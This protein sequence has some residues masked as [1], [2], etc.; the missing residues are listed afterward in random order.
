MLGR[1][2]AVSAQEALNLLLSAFPKKPLPEEVVILSECLGR[3]INRDVLAPEDLPGF[4]R[5]TVD[6]FA[7][8]SADTF[9]S[10]SYLSVIGEVRMGSAP[11]F[12]IKRGQTVRIPTGGMLP[13]GADSVLM[14]EHAQAIDSGMIEAQRQVAPGE[15]VITK[16]E[17][18]RQGDVVLRQGR[19]LRPQDIAALAGLGVI[20]V[21]VCAKPRVAVISTGDEVVPPASASLEGRVRDMNSFSLAGLI[22]RAGGIAQ[23]KGI[24]PDEYETIRGAVE[25]SL[26]DS[27]MVLISGGSS[28]GARDVVERV[29][30]SLGSVFFHGVAVKPGKPLM[31]G[32]ARGVPIYGLPGHPAAVVM[33]F[34]VFVMPVL[35]L[36][37]GERES[38]KA[39][40]VSAMLA[41]P[42]RSSA[43]R[44][45]YI[46]VSLSERDGIMYAEPV[47]GK[48]GLI[49]TLVKADGVVEVPEDRFGLEEGEA[50][51]VRLFT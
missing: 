18:A 28:V 22:A 46:R 31:A 15:N 47:L 12:I 32:E 6:G 44:R 27:D 41:S 5:S 30:A 49:S 45:D 35:R 48:S 29:V 23:V 50:V 42:V 4:D 34:D 2:E 11:P 37:S 38:P 14:L 43:G 51:E 17:D 10:Q 40:T 3:V 36:I 8:F 20:E 9:G 7:V 26:K 24:Y 1:G 39:G 16:G 19:R 21:S 25:G 13:A 33:C